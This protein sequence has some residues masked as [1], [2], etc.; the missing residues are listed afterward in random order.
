MPEQ[1]EEQ[2]QEIG[3]FLKTTVLTYKYYFLHT[4]VRVFEEKKYST[5]GKFFKRSDSDMQSSVACM[6]KRLAE[7][8]QRVADNSA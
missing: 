5:I 2:R 3:L 7:G 1:I 4:P 6:I 8:A